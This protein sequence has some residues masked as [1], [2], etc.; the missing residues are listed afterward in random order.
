MDAGFGLLPL[1]GLDSV[2]QPAL[3]EWSFSLFASEDAS[4]LGLPEAPQQEQKGLFCFC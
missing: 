4:S 1:S 3:D 2:T